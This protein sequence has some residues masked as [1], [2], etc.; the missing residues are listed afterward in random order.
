MSRIQI[1]FVSVPEIKF[2][3][4]K[5]RTEKKRVTQVNLPNPYIPSLIA[6]INSRLLSR[7]CVSLKQSP[8]TMLVSPSS[9]IPKFKNN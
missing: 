3:Q 4:K 9:S 2:H 7:K 6:E 1:L 5:K 8:F